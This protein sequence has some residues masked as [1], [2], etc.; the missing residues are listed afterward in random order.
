MTVSI[1]SFSLVE[2]D[3]VEKSFFY[4]SIK[5]LKKYGFKFFYQDWLELTVI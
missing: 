4:F 3:L 1:E 2:E 5:L